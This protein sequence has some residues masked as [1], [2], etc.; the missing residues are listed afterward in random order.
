M[1]NR[2]AEVSLE[3]NPAARLDVIDVGQEIREQ[4][5]HPD[6]ASYYRGIAHWPR[7][8]EAV[9]GRIS[10]LIDTAPYKER[11]RG[12]LAASRN[13]VLELPLPSRSEI[14]QRGLT[15]EQ[16]AELRA[17]LAVFRFRII[18]DMFLEVSLIKA[19]LDGPENARSSR[20]S[21]AR[22]DRQQAP[23]GES[24]F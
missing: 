24:S 21:F 22:A 14:L 10:P 6:V 12:L 16:V 15:E 17:I 20:F 23:K 9:W 13:T 2:P 8:L 1:S 7:F 4:H 3:V 11:K 19:L 5:G 18:S